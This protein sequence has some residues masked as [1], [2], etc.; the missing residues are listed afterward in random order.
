M[1]SFHQVPVHLKRVEVLIGI[2]ESKRHGGKHD[3]SY[4]GGIFLMCPKINN[5]MRSS[6]RLIDFLKLLI[7]LI[8]SLKL[9]PPKMT[10]TQRFMRE[11]ESVGLEP[12][13]V[14]EDI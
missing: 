3:T 7:F 6:N 2:L 11:K 5:L 1:V 12:E 14:L 8:Q 9:V 10:L 13:A 4:L